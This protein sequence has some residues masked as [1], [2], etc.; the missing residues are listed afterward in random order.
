MNRA[1]PLPTCGACRHHHHTA[2]TPSAAAMTQL[3]V[4]RCAIHTSYTYMAA[5]RPCLFDPPRWEAKPP[6]PSPPAATPAST[7]KATS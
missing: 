7:L 5:S 1:H 3:G 4:G 2:D 6:P